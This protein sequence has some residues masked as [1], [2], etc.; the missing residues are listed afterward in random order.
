MRSP[1]RP[2]VRLIDSRPTSA[3]AVDARAAT[4]TVM[5]RVSRLIHPDTA[6]LREKSVPSGRYAW[7]PMQKSS[8]ERA[9]ERRA[10]FLGFQP[11]AIGEE[12]G[13]AG[14]G[15]PRPRWPA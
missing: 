8:P 2:L 9:R 14:A 5:P 10:T 4:A 12:E 1:G 7:P 3:R 13:E 15:D 6:P 11:P